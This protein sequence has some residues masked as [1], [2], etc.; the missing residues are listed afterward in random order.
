MTCATNGCA[1]PRGAACHCAGCHLT[2]TALTPFD[3]HQRIDQGQNVC[4]DP[5]YLRDRR[6]KLV[7]REVRPG[8]WGENVDRP[9]IGGGA[10]IPPQHREAYAEIVRQAT[11][12]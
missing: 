3:R 12:Q 11:L 2:F 4:L 1:E 9:L 6:G 10:S 7:F 8:V 5:R